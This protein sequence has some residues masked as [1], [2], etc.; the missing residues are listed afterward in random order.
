M[1]TVSEQYIEKRLNVINRI[2]VDKLLND[3]FEVISADEYRVRLIIFDKYEFTF[4]IASIPVNLRCTQFDDNDNRL[5]LNFT[6]AEKEILHPKLKSFFIDE[7]K[8]PEQIAKR[9]AEFEKLKLEF[10]NI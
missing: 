7:S 2:F 4:W 3:E 1:K 8:N 9:R 5:N 10:E 6:E